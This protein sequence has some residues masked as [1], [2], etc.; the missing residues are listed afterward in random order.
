MDGQRVAYPKA[1][2]KMRAKA[3]GEVARLLKESY[4][5]LDRLISPS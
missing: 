5:V 1:E 4:L 3:L 2:V